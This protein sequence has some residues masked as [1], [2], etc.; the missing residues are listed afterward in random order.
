MFFTLITT[1]CTTANISPPLTSYGNELY[2]KIILYPT[3]K[4]LIGWL[5]KQTPVNTEQIRDV[6]QESVKHKSHELFMLQLTCRGFTFKTNERHK[7][8]RCE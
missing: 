5:G 8:C 6:I 1:T 4:V 2:R 7:G 3:H